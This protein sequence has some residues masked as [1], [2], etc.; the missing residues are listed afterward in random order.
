LAQGRCMRCYRLV[1]NTANRRCMPSVKIEDAAGHPV[2]GLREK[3]NNAA[4]LAVVCKE[5][6]VCHLMDIRGGTDKSERHFAVRPWLTFTQ[7]E[8]DFVGLRRVLMFL[9]SS[10]DRE[11]AIYTLRALAAMGVK[12]R[13]TVDADAAPRVSDQIASPVC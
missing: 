4:G 6:D 5:R 10:E 3:P 1:K 12:L 2:R 8:I 7:K 13:H 11:T 9:P